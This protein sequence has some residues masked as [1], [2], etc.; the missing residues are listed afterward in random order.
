M[1]GWDG[2]DWLWPWG[3]DRAKA[4]E[5]DVLGV[6]VQC[7]SAFCRWE[8]C[9]IGSVWVWMEQ[10]AQQLP[11]GHIL[12]VGAAA[13]AS[14]WSSVSFLM[15]E[16]RTCVQKNANHAFNMSVLWFITLLYWH[17][18]TFVNLPA[19]EFQH[20]STGKHQDRKFAASRVA[21]TALINTYRLQQG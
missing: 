21:A 18:E 19:V 2:G 14:S 1:T 12:Q 13:V 5:E 15:E 16:T 17:Y 3:R 10:E 6:E 4:E 11:S 7:P 8:A 20:S 9:L